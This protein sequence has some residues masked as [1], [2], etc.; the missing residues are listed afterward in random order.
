MRRIILLALALSLVSCAKQEE[1]P[2]LFL[3]NLKTAEGLD[4]A[5]LKSKY[6]AGL[7]VWF[8]D[9]FLTP[10]NFRAVFNCANYDSSLEPLRPLLTN[11]QFPDFLRNMNLI[12]KA[13]STRDLKDTLRDWIEEGPEGSSRVDRLLPTLSKIIKNP[14][15]QTALP[16]LDGILRAGESIW[17]EL[18]PGIADLLY[19]PRFP[20]NYADILTMMDAKSSGK[21]APKNQAKQI[22]DW[23]RFLKADLDGKTVALRGLELADHIKALD[24]P[25]TTVYEYLDQM[26][27]KGAIVSLYQETGALRG[28]V[29]NPKLNADPE[30]DE[31]QEGLSLTPEERQERARRKLYA[32]GADGSPA[33][34]VQ[35]AGM[36]AE[37]HQPH[38]DFLPAIARWVASHGST[39]SN[40]FFEYVS[41]SLVITSLT[42]INLETFLTEYAPK[43]GFDLSQPMVSADFTNFLNLAMHSAEYQAWLEANI[44]QANKEQFGVRN[45]ELLAGSP[46]KADILELYSLPAVAEF[47]GS[48][49]PNNKKLPLANAIKRFSNLHRGEKLKVEFR[50][51][52][53]SLEPHLIGLWQDAAKKS[54]GESVVVD[55]TIQL[56][57]TLFSQFASDFAAKNISVAQWY[58]SST[59][60]SP[61]SS[62][63]LAG[64]AFKELGLMAKYH[65]HKDYLKNTFSKEV[66]PNEEDQ[67]AFNLLVDQIPHIWLYIKSG[68]SRSGNDLTR[69]LSSKDR[70]Y[71]INHY[72]DAIASG[73]HTGIIREGVLLLEEYYRQFPAEAKAP[74]P[75]DILE[76]RRKISKGT[77]ALKRVLNSL[78][79][80]EEEGNYHSATLWQLIQPLS[81]IVAPERRAITEKFLLASA[82]ELLAVSDQNIDDFFRDLK[83][84]KAKDDD[85]VVS[86]RETMKAVSDLLKKDDFPKV[87]RQLSAFFQDEAVKPALDFL[88]QKIDDGTLTKVMLFLRRVLGFR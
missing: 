54:L 26:N 86:S 7:T 83:K 76:E 74:N 51:V 8:D 13:D 41:K 22:K 30:E 3:P 71:L 68:S 32:R 17:P 70:G 45:A 37:F 78:F 11:T 49:I 1:N 57:Q 67:R 40:G 77:D 9:D 80:P 5:S 84:E 38:K 23:A 73:F 10:E 64:Y 2:E 28:E 19:Q 14:S 53:Q 88:A 34:I 16:V 65:E 48:L 20:D 72:V 27:V 50:G 46:L 47:G 85:A 75:E 52:T 12:L 81:S 87:V 4:L 35:L 29:I 18:L 21:A 55:F 66:F 69:A 62:E 82:D 39:I 33:P 61:D 59:Y 15:F 56:V 43:A 79:E 60:G 58:F 6:C 24:L 63:A 31:L 42:K 25:G 36:V 44:N